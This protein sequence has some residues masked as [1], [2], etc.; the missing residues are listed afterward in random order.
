ME[1]RRCPVPRMLW[2]AA[3]MTAFALGAAGA[4]LPI[5]PT[6]PFMLLAAFCF[7]RSSDRL[8][9]WFRQTR[10]YK[11]VLEGYVSRRAMTPAAK[12]KLLI[13]TTAMLAL[14]FAL[15]GGVPAMRVV[16]AVIWVGHLV[17]FGL[18]VKTERPER[19][20]AAPS[21]SLAPEPEC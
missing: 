19:G 11:T 3:G 6:T 18:I 10:L 4:V 5:L 15:L 17:Y 16:I 1:K 12:L 21:P 20:T 13:P 7:A 9:A 2:G 14:S 8:E